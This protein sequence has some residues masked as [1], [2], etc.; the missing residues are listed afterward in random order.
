MRCCVAFPADYISPDLLLSVKR[1]VRLLST[2]VLLNVTSLDSGTSLYLTD[3]PPCV[4][5]DPFSKPTVQPPSGWVAPIQT[6]EVNLLNQLQKNV[7]PKID[8]ILL[9]LKLH[10]RPF[11][12]LKR[13][14][15]CT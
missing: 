14:L 9:P 1:V 7:A 2:V 10:A 15:V 6:P 4:C 8:L 13:V 3:S 12:S 5:I 11:P